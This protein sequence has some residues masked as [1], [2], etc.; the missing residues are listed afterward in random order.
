MGIEYYPHFEAADFLKDLDVVILSVPMVDFEECVNS[1]PVDQLIGK[2][3]VDVCPLNLEPRKIMLKA[4]KDYPE[5]DILVSNPMFGAYYPHGDES[6]SANFVAD[7][8]DGRPMVYER[9]RV[10]NMQRCD[11]YLKVFEEARCQ[12][13]EMDSDQHDKST[14]DAEFIT[15]MIGRLLDQKLLPPTPVMSK[16]Y[17][18]LSD[19]ADMTSNDSID[20]F[21]GM[22]KYNERAKDHLATMRENLAAVERQLAAREAYLSAK[23]EMKKSDRE[24]LLAETRLLLQELVKSSSQGQNDGQLADMLPNVLDLGTNHTSGIN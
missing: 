2:L 21:F 14:A 15:H 10:A 9:V 12:V 22:Y 13:V 17:A 6:L 18:A 23:A 19:V 7:L 5:I 8:W 20:L 4:F 11:R 1:L 3:V 16:E 24:R